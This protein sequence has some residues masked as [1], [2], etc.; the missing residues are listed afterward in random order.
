MKRNSKGISKIGWMSTQ[1]EK[2]FK[3]YCDCKAQKLPLRLIVVACVIVSVIWVAGFLVF[4]STI[5]ISA[6]AAA[7]EQ[8]SLERLEVFETYCIQTTELP[9]CADSPYLF[10]IS[11]NDFSLSQP[12]STPEDLTL[13]AESY[14]TQIINILVPPRNNY[15]TPCAMK[16]ID[17]YEN[18]PE[19]DIP[20]PEP[21]IQTVEVLNAP[22]T[23]ARC[24]FKSWMDWRAITARN[25][26]QW[27]LQQI[28]YTCDDG[29][30]RVDGMYMIALGT[31]FLYN[32][33]GDVFD[34]T[35]SSGVTFRAVVGDVKS[36]NHTDPTNRFHL[37]DGSVIEF[38]VD[39]QVMCRS[40]LSMGNI[41][42]A[43]FP[44][45]ITSIARVPE[46]FI[47]V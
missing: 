34:I 40:I 3:T 2:T 6:N 12:Y 13:E 25:S 46:L 1:T 19:P 4:M 37:S 28:A 9:A 17:Y 14:E 18:I 44:G 38:L 43:G 7:E 10:D 30:R 11:E 26:R 41:S 39:R 42:V 8:K 27:R 35:L 36:N 29:F 47:P 16:I 5:E 31:Y 32:G 23:Q 21:E 20:E 24:Y 45:T 33:V 15:L 22:I